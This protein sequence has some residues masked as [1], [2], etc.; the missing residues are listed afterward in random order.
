MQLY[1]YNYSYLSI[2]ATILK[3]ALQK[4]LVVDQLQC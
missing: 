1:N 4:Y 3:I 2:V